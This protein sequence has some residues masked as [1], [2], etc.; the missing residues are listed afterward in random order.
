MQSAQAAE[1]AQGLKAAHQFELSIGHMESD[2]V[3]RFLWNGI[4]WTLSNVLWRLEWVVLAIAVCLLALVWFKRFDPDYAR[5]AAVGAWKSMTSRFRRQP[6]QWQPA[7]ES[8]WTVGALPQT[9]LDR[10]AQAQNYFEGFQFVAVLLAELR[11]M[12]RS[13]PK[14][15]YAADHAGQLQRHRR[16]RRR[17]GEPPAISVA[18]SGITLV[19]D[20]HPRAPR[21]HRCSDVLRAPFLPAPAP[22]L[23]SAGALV[24]LLSAAGMIFRALRFGDLHL[25]AACLAGAVFIPSL[26]LA[27]GVW[28]NTPRLFEALYVGLWYLALNG[29]PF[30]DFMGL[31]TALVAIDLRCP[32]RLP[33]HRRHAAALVGRRTRS[34]AARAFIRKPRLMQTTA[35]WTDPARRRP[36][37]PTDLR[38]WRFT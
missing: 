28:S 23:W 19:A 34:S 31:T 15:A 29:A 30:A 20:G 14:S 21:R 25:L 35:S 4:P 38:H 27:C 22:A 17:K 8:K 3:G 2:H 36:I 37:I 9:L 24:A 32:R 12:L 16:S 26:A 13:V 1:A 11:L 33:L 7:K 10:S 18:C 6:A 5:S